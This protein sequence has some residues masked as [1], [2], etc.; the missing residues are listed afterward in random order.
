MISGPIL[1]TSAGIKSSSPRWLRDLPVG[2]AAAPHCLPTVTGVLVA[3]NKDLVAAAV[4]KDRV[5]AIWSKEGSMQQL[6]QGCHAGTGIMY[7]IKVSEENVVTMAQDGTV[8][9]LVPCE[10]RWQVKWVFSD[11]NFFASILDC[12]G[13]W[14]ARGKSRRNKIFG[15]QISLW[16][17]GQ[18]MKD[19]SVD[20]LVSTEPHL[21][22]STLDPGHLVDLVLHPPYIILSLWQPPSSFNPG[23]AILRVCRLDTYDVVKTFGN[24]TGEL[25][26]ADRLVIGQGVIGQIIWKRSSHP[27]DESSRE[28]SF[29]RVFQISDLVDE[30]QRDNID[31]HCKPPCQKWIELKDPKPASISMNL[32]SLVT[33]RGMTLSIADFWVK[34]GKGEE[35]LERERLATEAERRKLEEEA[36]IEELMAS[37]PSYVQQDKR[38]G[39]SG[40]WGGKW[41][42]N[43]KRKD[44]WRKGKRR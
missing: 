21:R 1:S 39:D 44:D 20:D 7:D 15:D 2:Q 5:T 17:G 11:E 24:V 33:A 26:Q 36:R 41:R 13:D 29:L 34:R 30:V 35:E 43:K 31:K 16:H 6:H 38:D 22:D 25:G 23:H 27:G 28:V 18:K 9:V 10:G 12:H 40:G 19:I 37:R 32:T 14:V 3:G 42:G 4:I 8:V